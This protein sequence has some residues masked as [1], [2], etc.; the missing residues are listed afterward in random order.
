MDAFADDRSGGV[1]QA[2]G[3][4][5]RRVVRLVEEIGEQIPQRG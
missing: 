1:G 2:V 5:R 4:K 3:K